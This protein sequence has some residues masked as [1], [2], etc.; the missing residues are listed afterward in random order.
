MVMN[1]ILGLTLLLG[2]LAGPALA[3]VEVTFEAAD[4]VTVHADRYAHEGNRSRG[5]ILLFHQASGN[6]GE[7]GEI[8]PRLAAMGFEAIAIDQR[9]GGAMFMARN[10]TLAGLDAPAMFFDDA[11]ADLEAALVYAR[12]ERP[13]DGIIVWGSS[14]SA[15]LAI[16]LAA[17][18]PD[19]VIAALAF[20]PS[21]LSQRFD[22]AEAAARLTVP[23]FV[24]YATGPSERLQAKTIAG[25]APAGL[26]TLHTPEVGA[27]GSVTLV[28]AH[29]PRG[30]D[31]NWAAVV[32][33]LDRVAP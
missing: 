9:L 16:V 3:Q 10:R 24:S 26:A 4:G 22:E 21:F 12:A 33:F 32:A 23:L 18:N 19:A 15:G 29:N 2:H 5:T 17:E 6:A 30:A 8:A 13:G 1:G 20:S 7:Y 11:L 27:H 25:A 28:P 14:Y 31:A